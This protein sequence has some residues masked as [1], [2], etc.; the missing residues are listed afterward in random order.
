MAKKNPKFNGP[1]PPEGG[2]GQPS[3]YPFKKWKVG[4]TKRY[5]T[6]EYDKI[7]NAVQNLNRGAKDGGGRWRYAKVVEN[8]KMFVRVWRVE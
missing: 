2:R 4:A 7:R 5:P 3:P 8:G 6:D 1:P